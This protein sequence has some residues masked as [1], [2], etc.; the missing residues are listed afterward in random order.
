VK[1]K[2]PA[3]QFKAFTQDIIYIMVK[4]KNLVIEIAK[5]ETQQFRQK[6][7]LLQMNFYFYPRF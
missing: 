1:N 7:V 5:K 4:N 3:Y 2:K 6:T